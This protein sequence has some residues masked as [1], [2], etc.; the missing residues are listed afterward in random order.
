[1]DRPI[2]IEVKPPLPRPAG[3]RAG[4]RGALRAP[5]V[6]ALA[7]FLVACSG[8]PREAAVAPAG[9][10]RR[11][12]AAEAKALAASPDGAWLAWLEACHV[13][14][15]QYL[16]PGT[17]N[18]DL[19]VGPA[20]GG[21]AQRIAGAV[22][23]LPH[24]IAWSPAGPAL[25]ALADYDYAAGAG[26]LVL[27]EG[28]KAREVARGVTFHGFGP[29]GELGFVAGGRLQ[30]LGAGEESPREVAGAEGVASFDFAPRRA[31]PCEGDR[32]LLLARRAR[33][34][35]GD[36]L[37]V[38]CRLRP[39][40]PL[41]AGVAEY[42]FAPDGSAFAATIDGRD[43]P[44]LRVRR[45]AGGGAATLGRQVQ[46]F[47]FA[48]EGGGV[49]FLGDV[50]PGRQGN[51]YVAE[52]GRAPSL[53]GKEVGDFRWA[54]RAPRLAWLE[55]FDPRVRSGALG[56]GGPGTV[57]RSLGRNVTD[58]DLA[59]DGRTVAYL[60][61]TTRG[62][63]S[64]DLGLA[65]VDGK[66]PPAVV[67][68]GVFG[69]AFSPDG[70][71]LYYRTRCTRNGEGCDLERVPA[72]GLAKDGKP[73]PI[74]PGMKS[75]EFDPRDPGRLLVGWQRADRPALDIATWR[76]GKLTRIDQ[77]VLPGSARFV[78]AVPGRVVYAV[79]DP[80]RAGLYVADVP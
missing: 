70:K 17:S 53:L 76:D 32:L 2:L 21:E 37:G 28:G 80:K 67:A 39:L 38:D 55:K 1:M 5:L 7:S 62:G 51:L 4:E 29:G 14:R 66:G 11:A 61:H 75:F 36:L 48:P 79:V 13:A 26:T 63:Y 24:G 50:A 71:W 3:E 22:T 47:A 42:G 34:A 31:G 73:E 8:A 57:S 74:A 44:L 68:H 33:A 6:V 15:G 40:A 60:Q 49:A 18:C 30:L 16:P 46:R 19:R 59:P 9:P 64:V 69:F 27:W 12:A 54:A 25:A 45:T 52:P 77:V 20:A 43:G 23:T 65:A 41:A 10:G 35:G 78:A 56:V 58:F 72:E